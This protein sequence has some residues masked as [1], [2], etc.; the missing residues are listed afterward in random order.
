MISPDRDIL[1]A[2]VRLRGDANFEKLTSWMR[3]SLDRQSR[4]NNHVREG[5]VSSQNKGRNLELEELL[6]HIE[7]AETDLKRLQEQPRGVV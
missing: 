7:N 1:M 3:L 4:D 6:G 5:D 2:I